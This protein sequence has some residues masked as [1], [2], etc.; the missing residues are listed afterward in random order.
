MYDNE[1]V[2]YAE[3]TIDLLQKLKV[4]QA[5]TDRL[6]QPVAIIG[7]SDATVVQ[8]ACAFR[9]AKALAAT[10]MTIVCG[11]K[12][13]VMEA[14]SNGVHQAGGI[15]IGILPD[16]DMSL[17]NPFLTIALPTG[18]GEARNAIIARSAL[19]MVAVGGGL[20]TISEM[21]LGLKWGKPVFGISDAEYVPG[22]RYFGIEDELVY[23]TV[24]W[25]IHHNLGPLRPMT[26][27]CTP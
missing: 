23:E 13:G 17:A 10:G 21:A 14:A 25:L 19:C 18:L 4:R 26:V 22:A 7:P 12:G 24:K 6:R 2:S 5:G 15:V 1:N 8:K 3:S 27:S 9:I 11:G 20:G 16:D